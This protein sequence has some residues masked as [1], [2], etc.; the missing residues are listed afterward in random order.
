MTDPNRQKIIEKIDSSR[1]HAVKFLQDMVAIPSV[2]GDEAAIQRFMNDYLTG[3]GLDVDM[4]ET[5]WEELK[6]HPGY[7][8]VARGYEGR[9]NIVAT[10]KG[11]GGG[12]SLL[13]N[14]HT[15]VI[16]VGNGEG[17]SDDPWS[18]KIENGR[19]YGRGSCDMKSGV[20][21]HVLAVQYLKELG[22]TPKGDVLI[23]IVIDEEVSGHGTL[24]TVIRGYKADAGISGETSDL[25]VQPACIGRIWFEIEI[26]GKPAGIQ[27]RYL[28]ISGIALG[29]KIVEAVQELEDHRVATVK[30]PL[31]PSAIDSLPCI[32]GSFQAGNYPSAFP[33]SAL[34]KGSI[35]TVPGEDHEGVKRSLVRKIAEC[36]AED[37]WMKDHPPVVRFVGYD[38]EA[39]EI[40]RD[41]AIVGTVGSVY[42]ELTGKEPIISGRQG[43]ADTRFLNSYGKTPTVIFGPGSTAIMHANDE[44]VSIDDYLTAIKVM[45]L[46]IY[47]WCNGAPLQRA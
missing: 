12:R 33:A 10:L 22:L 2:T 24:D 35:G 25:H 45:A 29:R 21:S 27:Q 39:S 9:P 42:T 34:L 43:A 40:P 37:P 44:Y 28:G 19:I 13:L 14:G 6:N 3:I 47:D 20:A 8:P 15:D 46:S 4:W 16:P 18:A 5:D 32:I 30:H 26:H 17:W 7:R 1:D 31:Y 38:A 11:T 23:N 41:H 36:A